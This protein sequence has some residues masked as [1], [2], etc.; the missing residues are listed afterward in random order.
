MKKQFKNPKQLCQLTIQNSV[1]GITERSIIQRS[2]AERSI[3]D[4]SIT[5]K[6]IT[7]ST[8]TDVE[9]REVD[10]PEVVHKEVEHRKGSKGTTSGAF[11]LLPF[12]SIE[13]STNT[14]RSISKRS[15]TEKG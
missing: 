15:F 6:S 11:Y 4:R 13:G 2:I 14:E 3:T 9:H 8:N 12:K 10:H 7:G 5:E 1:P